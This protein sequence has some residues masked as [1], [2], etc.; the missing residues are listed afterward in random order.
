MLCGVGITQYWLERFCFYWEEYF[1]QLFQTGY[2]M[3]HAPIH[4]FGLCP[5]VP[6]LCPSRSKISKDFQ[7]KPKADE[8]NPLDSNVCKRSE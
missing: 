6:K 7:T 4:V 1:E 2:V 8:T 5:P 3:K